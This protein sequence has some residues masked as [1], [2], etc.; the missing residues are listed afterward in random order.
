MLRPRRRTDAPTCFRWPPKAFLLASTHLAAVWGV[1]VSDD[2]DLL[3][4]EVGEIARG[5]LT[6]KVGDL[7]EMVETTAVRFLDME[8]SESSRCHDN[9]RGFGNDCSVFK[10]RCMSAHVRRFCQKTCNSCR[11]NLKILQIHPNNDG[12]LETFQWGAAVYTI[13][14]L[15]MVG[16]FKVLRNV[17]PEIYMNNVLTGAASIDAVPSGIWGWW[18]ASVG[19]TTDQMVEDLGLDAGMFLEYLNLCSR[20]LVHMGIPMVLIMAPL[21]FCCGGNAAGDDRLSYISL[22]NVQDENWI[23]W[24]HAFLVWYVV[25]GSQRLIYKAQAD[26]IDRRFQWLMDQPVTQACTV[27]VQNVP[28]EYRSDAELAKLFQTLLPG[29]CVAGAYLAKDTQTLVEAIREK[30]RVSQKKKRA[31]ELDKRDRVNELQADV[32][33]LEAWI[34]EERKRLWTASRVVAGV[35]CCHG[36]VTFSNRFAREMALNLPVSRDEAELVLQAPPEPGSLRWDDLKA[37]PQREF[38]MSLV[39]YFLFSAI[40]LLYMPI[41]VG[42]SLTAQSTNLGPFQ[43]IWE[44]VAPALALTLLVQILPWLLFSIGSYFFSLDDD[45]WAQVSLNHWY[46]WFQVT[47]VILVTAIGTSVGDFIFDVAHRP[48]MVARLFV[49]TAPNVTHFY[50]NYLMSQCFAH[51]HA[52]LRFP[53]LCR[54]ISYKK[55]MRLDMARAAAEP[56]CQ[57][58]NGLGNRSARLSIA[59][60]IAIL[61]CSCC[62]VILLV[63]FVLVDICRVTYGY[64]MP[65]AETRKPDAGGVVFVQQLDHL[66]VAYFAY[67]ILMTGVLF[68][69]METPIPAYIAG[70]AAIWVIWSWYRFGT[71]FSWKKL[72]F[73]MLTTAQRA[74]RN[75]LVSQDTYVQPEMLPRHV[76]PSQGGETARRQVDEVV[77]RGLFE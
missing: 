64:L 38:L 15:V 6:S 65:F 73:K 47:F 11:E 21:H 10:R 68:L 16:A 7:T 33:A 27:M 37:H 41:V 32:D 54:F 63:T 52:L 58:S 60:M 69:R 36:F 62:P 30:E 48:S 56:E 45:A 14:T 17:Y 28:F 40:F 13:L 61:F 22:G 31:Q 72:P 5:N 77:G 46:F 26:F 49:E 3:S 18:R 76:P 2:D 51:A 43:H 59:M 23:Y 67:V 19:V 42:I 35:N 1:L 20:I 25:L 8:A 39:G 24:V 70:S 74:D 75:H 55:E 50:L 4:D 71:T 66:F 57:A 29:D 44:G 9:N 12:D 34:I 53:V